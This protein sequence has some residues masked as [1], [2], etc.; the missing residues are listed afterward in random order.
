M[1]LSLATMTV[2]LRNLRQC[3]CSLSA[4]LPKVAKASKFCIFM[5]QN[6]HQA[7]ISA[8]REWL[9]VFLLLKKYLI[10]SF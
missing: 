1:S 10:F 8:W 5:A 6:H 2:L 9:A 7:S 3:K 4:M